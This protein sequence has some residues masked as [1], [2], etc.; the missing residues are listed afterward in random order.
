MFALV[1]P[2]VKTQLPQTQLL[3]LM[4]EKSLVPHFIKK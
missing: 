2:H 1:T 4:L 3:Q